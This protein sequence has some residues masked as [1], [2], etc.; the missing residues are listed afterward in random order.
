M[1]LYKRWN[2][3][4]PSAPPLRVIDSNA[5]HDC[6]EPM[7]HALVGADRAAV[8]PTVEH[9]AAAGGAVRETL[10]LITSAITNYT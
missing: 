3:F 1:R 5:C 6:N 4:F 2:L 7:A 10:V 9:M 8:T